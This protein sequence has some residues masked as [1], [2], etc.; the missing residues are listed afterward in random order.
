[1]DQSLESVQVVSMSNKLRNAFNKRVHCE[2]DIHLLITDIDSLG[3][4]G[5][6]AYCGREMTMSLKGKFKHV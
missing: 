4:S 2:Y 5:K 6:C 1:M 3:I